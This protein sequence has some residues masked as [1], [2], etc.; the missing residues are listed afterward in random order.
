VDSYSLHIAELLKEPTVDGWRRE[1]AALRAGQREHAVI[2]AGGGIQEYVQDLLTRSA[3]DARTVFDDALDDVVRR[4]APT[5]SGWS[6]DL[7][8]MLELIGAFL[9]QPGFQKVLLLLDESEPIAVL[10][11]ATSAVPPSDLYIKGLTV[12]RRYYRVAPKSPKDEG[13]AFDTYL[14]LLHSLILHPRHRG[15]AIARLLELNE[16]Q[17]SGQVLAE[18]IQTDPEILSSIVPALLRPGRRGQLQRDL[19]A[20]YEHCVEMPVAEASFTSSLERFGY[21][22]EM[23]DIAPLIRPREGS[24]FTL[25]LGPHA[26]AYYQLRFLEPSDRAIDKF[27][28]LTGAHRLQSL[29]RGERTRPGDRPRGPHRDTA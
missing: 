6:S 25:E 14:S 18:A 3:G 27:E 7:A 2:A 4:W 8:C 17:A 5:S 11:S 10:G 21:T 9:P 24:P 19:S 12:L 28:R 13:P 22:V 15:Y 26:T 20:L 1:L 23:Q 29:R 16:V